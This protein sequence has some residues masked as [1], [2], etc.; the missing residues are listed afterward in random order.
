MYTKKPKAQNFRLFF[1]CSADL[2]APRG[3]VLGH[4]LSRQYHVYQLHDIGHIDLT[5]AVDVSCL[6]VDA[7]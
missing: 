4:L 2:L 1:C 5:I 3:V 7:C 6:V